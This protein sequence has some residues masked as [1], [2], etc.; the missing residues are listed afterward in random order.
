MEN[1]FK[2]PS[3]KKNSPAVLMPLR[4]SGLRV[5][6]INEMCPGYHGDAVRPLPILAG[7]VAELK[8]YILL[9]FFKVRSVYRSTL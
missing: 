1:G 9:F 5:I 3:F 2:D 8:A 4:P 6:V 7:Y